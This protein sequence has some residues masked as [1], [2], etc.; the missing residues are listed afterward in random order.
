MR[1]L[2]AMSAL[3]VMLIV[4]SESARDTT[5]GLF[6]SAARLPVEAIH[7][8]GSLSSAED[9]DVIQRYCIRCHSDLRLTGNLSLEAFDAAAPEANAVVAER[10]VRKLRA[11]MMPPPGARRPTGDTL[12]R[13]VEGLEARLDASAAA[14]PNPGARTFQRLN[15]IEY[16][17][18]ILDLLALEVNAGA[19]LPLDTKSANFDNIADVQLLSP[20]LLDAYMNAATEISRLAVGDRD[21]LPSTAT[22]TNP[23]YVTQWDRMEG[24]PFGT[25]G[26]LSVTHSFPADA[27]YV[28]NLAFEHTTTGGFFGGTTPDEQIEISV[29]G[30]RVQ[31]LDVDRWMDVADPNG[32]NMRSEPIFVRAG[33]HR[34]TAAFLVQSEGPK[35]DLVSPHAWSLTDRQVGVAGY[36]ITALAHLK[37][38]AIVGPY[39]AKGVS[40]TPS[41]DRIFT[42]RPT[43][44]GEAR[45]CAE[46]IMTRLARQ[47]FRRPVTGADVEGLMSF[48][49]MGAAGAGFERGV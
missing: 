29:D 28:F 32:A 42:C 25:R 49:E 45:P 5:P 21:A 4:A 38:L 23:G 40:D 20:T 48:Y 41:R 34:V 46:E 2:T 7:G 19:F 27:E 13:L 11:G 37:D 12:L 15:R 9:N 24:A 35:E 36:G 17:R 30:E 1:I 18:S 44:S 47:A 39:N 8:T 16:E 43:S 26:G 33:P 14:N 3:G 31:L 6:P 22:Y 10:M